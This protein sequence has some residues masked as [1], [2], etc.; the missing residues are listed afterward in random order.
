[1]K[2]IEA[3]VNSVAKIASVTV[4]GYSM[5]ISYYNQQEQESIDEIDLDKLDNIFKRMA[6]FYLRFRVLPNHTRFKKYKVK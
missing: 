1:M 2:T 5:L 4:P 3:G 6:E